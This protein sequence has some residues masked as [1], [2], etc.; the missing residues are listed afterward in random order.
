[1]HMQRQNLN[2]YVK[3]ITDQTES[4]KKTISEPSNEKTITTTDGLKDL[5]IKQEGGWRLVCQYKQIMN[6]IKT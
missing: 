2:L 3:K 6:A 4:K 1:M 5:I